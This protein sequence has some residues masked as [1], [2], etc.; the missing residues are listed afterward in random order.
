MCQTMIRQVS[1][2]ALK[3]IRLRE[4][5]LIIQLCPVHHP[6]EEAILSL[7]PSPIRSNILS[8]RLPMRQPITSNMGIRALQASLKPLMAI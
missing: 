5:L 6:L 2:E 3:S 8:I 7:I 4:Q 1:E